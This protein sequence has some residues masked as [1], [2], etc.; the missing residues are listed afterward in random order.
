MGARIFGQ[1]TGGMKGA[2]YAHEKTAT[3]GRGLC[4][5]AALFYYIATTGRGFILLISSAGA[6]S[7]GFAGFEDFAYVARRKRDLRRF[8]AWL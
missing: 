2:I 7:R 6:G 5:V 4:A 1:A 8:R 3:I